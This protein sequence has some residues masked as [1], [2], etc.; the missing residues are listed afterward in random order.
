VR[1]D[2]NVVRQNKLRIA[3]LIFTFSS[4][5][6]SFVLSF[7]SEARTFFFI[8]KI[9]FEQ[10]ELLLFCLSLYFFSSITKTMYTRIWNK[11]IRK[12]IV[13]LEQ[14]QAQI[15]AKVL[16]GSRGRSIMKVA[17]K[18]LVTKRDKTSKLQW[19]RH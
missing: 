15:W 2:S 7:I 9:F 11:M 19:I 6:F 10:Q 5:F 14:P 16:G 18:F 1:L 4:L 8:S 12:S 17:E 13:Y 3:A